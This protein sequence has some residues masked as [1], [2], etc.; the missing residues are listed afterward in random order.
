MPAKR[1]LTEVT[2]RFRVIRNIGMFVNS[3]LCVSLSLT[4]VAITE[5]I[6]H[7]FFSVVNSSFK[8]KRTLWI[9]IAKIQQLR[10]SLGHL[11]SPGN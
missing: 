2:G 11:N 3:Y 6:L 5:R 8:L 7:F 9:Q 1:I 10:E 4:D